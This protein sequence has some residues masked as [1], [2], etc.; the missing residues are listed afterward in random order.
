[1]S[2]TVSA[3]V[4]TYNQP[5]KLRVALASIELQSRPVDEVIVVG[6]HCLA[7]TASVVGEFPALSI[8][9]VNL[10]LRCGEQAIPNA[11]GTLLAKGTHVAYLNHD[12]LW[13]PL[14]IESA[15]KQLVASK[16]RWFIGSAAFCDDFPSEDDSR[17][18]MFSSRT[19]RKRSVEDSFARSYLYL[20]PASS[21]VFER[22][23]V[24]SAGNWSPAWKIARTPV[25]ELPLRMWRK[26]GEPKFGS[27]VSV[28]KILGNRSSKPG[29][30]YFHS[31]ELH[32]FLMSVLKQHSRKWADMFVWPQL[33]SETR[34]RPVID[35]I[36]RFGLMDL[37]E[38][39]VKTST[40]IY[41]LAGIDI[42][43]QYLRKKEGRGRLLS[44]MLASRTGETRLSR[45]RVRSLY[46]LLENSQ[47]GKD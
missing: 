9:Y 1:V 15:L 45:T 5:D 47:L 20:E 37:A 30:H 39:L 12:D 14:H 35:S 29:P 42:I 10:P 16:V 32:D 8:R 31:T 22:A 25:S 11:I 13:L 33:V 19:Q 34:N 3:I 23:A 43:E 44:H 21:W 41:R 17:F 26:Y 27:I 46:Q 6:D 2:P 28:A 18:H 24:L 7:E 4:S 38:R 36:G 40:L